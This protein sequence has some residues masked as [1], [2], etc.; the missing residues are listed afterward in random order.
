MLSPLS[1]LKV[2]KRG[3]FQPMDTSLAGDFLKWIMGLI[4][5]FGLAIALLIAV[6]L[7]GDDGTQVQVQTQSQAATPAPTPVP[8]ITLYHYTDCFSSNSINLS[9]FIM[10]SVSGQSGGFAAFGS[11]VYLTDLPPAALLNKVEYS[12]TLFDS[13]NVTAKT[14]CWLLVR[15][16]IKDAVRVRSV[17]TNKLS[18]A[19]QKAAGNFSIYLRKGLQNLPLDLIDLGKTVYAP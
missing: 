8:T 9:G 12:L 16:P 11:G 6:S 19:G 5:L 4:L 10:P 13:P 1:N 18:K 15:L 14:A 3:G 17:Y 2:E 7:L